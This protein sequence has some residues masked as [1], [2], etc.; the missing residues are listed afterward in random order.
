MESHS[1]GH[2]WLIS[3]YSRG[4]DREDH[5]LKPAQAN[6]SQDPISK[7]PSQEELA[8]WLKVK[9]LS[10]SPSTAKHTE[11]FRTHNCTGVSTPSSCYSSIASG[12]VEPNLAHWNHA[13]SSTTH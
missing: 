11:H 1:D 2:Q 12:T 3:S 13:N 6:I 4:R 10:S 9:A 7:N 8:E 5:G